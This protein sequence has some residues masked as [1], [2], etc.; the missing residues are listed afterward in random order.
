VLLARVL[1]ALATAGWV[2]AIVAAPAAAL[3]VP[4]SGIVYA[5]SSYICHQRPER[6]FHLAGAQLPVCARCFGLYLGGAV[7]ALGA[8]AIAALKG[9]APGTGGAKGSGGA[10]GE[11]CRASGDMWRRA[12]ALRNARAAILLAALPTAI[13]WSAET[14]GLWSP[15]NVTRFA[16]ALPLGAIVALTVNYVECA[17]RRPNTSRAPRTPI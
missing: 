10:T 14:A 8:A 1:L 4:A 11:D 5:A 12:S 15:S 2:V 16:A 13:T 9:R 17:R 7:G 3:G 6:S